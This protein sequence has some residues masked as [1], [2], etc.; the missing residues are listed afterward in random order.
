MPSVVSTCAPMSAAARRSAP[1]DAARAIRRRRARRCRSCPTRMPASRR[2][3]VPALPQSI[4]RLGVAQRRAARRPRRG[5]FTLIVDADPE[6][7]TAAAVESVSAERPKPRIVAHAFGDRREQE[8]P[9]GDRLVARHG[10]VAAQALAGSILTRQAPRRMRA[11]RSRSTPGPRAAPP[12]RRAASTPVTSTS[13]VPPRSGVMWASRSP[14]MLMPCSASAWVIPE[15]PPAGRD[16]HLE[17]LELPGVAVRLFEEPAAVARRLAD[18]ARQEAGIA[19]RE[20]TLE[21]FDPPAVLLERRPELRGVVEED[22][23]PDLGGSRPRRGSCP[24]SDPPAAA[25]GSCPSI[26]VAPAWLR[27]RFARACGR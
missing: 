8:R 12:P 15:T 24:R 27:R 9:M 4:G 3:S 20:S 11:Q 6:G 23:D 19:L 5:R 25:S 14:S 1:A 2:I 10:H 18:P 22:V 7:R 26:L 17:A 21:I 13:S 16:V